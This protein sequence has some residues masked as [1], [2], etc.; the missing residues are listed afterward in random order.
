MEDFARG[1]EDENIERK[2][3]KPMHLSEK[4]RTAKRVIG[5]FLVYQQIVNLKKCPT[6]SACAMGLI[7]EIEK[8]SQMIC[9]LWSLVSS[10][11]PLMVTLQGSLKMTH[12]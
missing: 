12:L 4:Q 2:N 11:A 6:P 7:K 8:W 1:L 9:L 3:S 5:I 10:M